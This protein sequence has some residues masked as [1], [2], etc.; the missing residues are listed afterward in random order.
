MQNTVF[1]FS[2]FLYFFSLSVIYEKTVKRVMSKKALKTL[3]FSH[4]SLIHAEGS[5]YLPCLFFRHSATEWRE[6][7]FI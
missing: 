4:G 6:E 2:G 1:C 7:R 5:F 3:H